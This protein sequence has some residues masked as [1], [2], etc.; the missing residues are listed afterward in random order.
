MAGNLTFFPLG[1]DDPAL[2]LTN[3]VPPGRCGI[4]ANGRGTTAVGI[5]LARPGF[6]IA[7]PVTWR[8]VE[9]GISA[10]AF[11]MEHAVDKETRCNLETWPSE[12]DSGASATYHRSEKTSSGRC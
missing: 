9:Q 7:V 2:P 5:F 10:G 6:S 12:V 11:D 4:L 3:G 1:I 8:Q